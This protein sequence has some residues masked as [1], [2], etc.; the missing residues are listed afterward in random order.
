MVANFQF[1]SHG[2]IMINRQSVKP[3]SLH[4]LGLSLDLLVNFRARAEGQP[5][6]VV[7][8]SE[9]GSYTLGHCYAVAGKLTA[10]VEVEPVPLAVA[11]GLVS[12]VDGGVVGLG[13]K[14]F[15]IEALHSM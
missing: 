8:L 5:H 13:S 12:S 10:D 7:R 3:F 9:E 11:V 14:K 2:P 1:L 4:R 15:R 6:V